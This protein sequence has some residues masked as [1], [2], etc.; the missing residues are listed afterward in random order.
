MKDRFCDAL[1]DLST[2]QCLPT[3]RPVQAYVAEVGI[4]VGCR[5]T[6]YPLVSGAHFPELLNRTVAVRDQ[7]LLCARTPG[8]LVHIGRMRPGYSFLTFLI[9]RYP[10]TDICHTPRRAPHLAYKRGVEWGGQNL[11]RLLVLCH[12]KLFVA[13]Q[14]YQAVFNRRHHVQ[15]EI[16]RQPLVRRHHRRFCCCDTP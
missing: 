9:L 2:V 6:D 8:Q 11:R 16:F 14:L 15:H 1:E 4:L 3:L 12:I 10:P 5:W 13:L 7:R